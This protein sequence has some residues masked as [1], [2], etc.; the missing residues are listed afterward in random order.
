MKEKIKKILWFILNPRFL[1]CFG[2]AWLITNGWCY[3]FIAVGGALGIE[4]MTA[5]GAAY[6]AFLWL[7]ISPEKIATFAISIALLKLI[8]PKDEKTLGVLRGLYTKAKSAFKNRKSKRR[9][10]K[11][12]IE[13]GEEE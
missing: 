7:P 8:F 12:C 4:W 2:L 13:K 10:D 3:I 9:R 6:F 11:Q 5:V 1:L